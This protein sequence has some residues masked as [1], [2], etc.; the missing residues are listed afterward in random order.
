MPQT[1]NN[2]F[3][4]TVTPA[5]VIGKTR[6]YIEIPA[7]VES[8]TWRGV[9]TVAIQFNYLASEGFVLKDIPAQP[10]NANFNLAIKFVENEVVTRY[11]LWGT[12]NDIPEATLY[13]KQRINKDFTIEVW[14]KST[15]T[16]SV[17]NTS[18]IRIYT[19][20]RGIRDV[21]EETITEFELASSTLVNNMENQVTSFPLPLSVDN[22]P[23]IAR[24][25]ASV[26]V[27][28][29]LGF[30]TGWNDQVT[31]VV[32][33]F[34]QFQDNTVFVNT[35][36]L[37][38]YDVL[39]FNQDATCKTNTM[40]GASAELL[41]LFLLIKINSWANNKYITKFA[42]DTGLRLKGT[43]PQAKLVIGLEESASFNLPINEWIV[44]KLNINELNTKLSGATDVNSLTNIA[45]IDNTYFFDSE[46][47]LGGASMSV[48]EIIA[49]EGIVS[50]NTEVFNYL[51]SKYQTRF[52]FPIAYTEAQV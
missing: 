24:W 20:V 32:F 28:N 37:N 21:A 29:S 17:N 45:E 50:S 47:T 38:G 41:T 42:T 10:D 23:L 31:G 13:N 14:D 40:P 51:Q 52:K 5:T 49:Y 39:T 7:F 15:A 36:T 25:D 3:W 11:I 27:N 4:Q 8:N 2:N 12:L 26:G 48:A 43:S 34:E 6:S 1:I 46:L 18:V 19:S 22:S 44:I 33:D 30:V 35:A 9:P 16:S